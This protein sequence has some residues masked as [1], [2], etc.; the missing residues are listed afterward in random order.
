MGDI[1]KIIAERL[2]T[3]LNDKKIKQVELA[4]ILDIEPSAVSGNLLKGKFYPSGENLYKLA[5]IGC[6]INWLL[7]GE[8]LKKDIPD[9]NVEIKGSSNVTI[10]NIND[11]SA[12]N[13]M[14]KELLKKYLD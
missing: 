6:D 13:K 10:G 12:E 5:K 8:S 4:K 7:T 14:L 1:K 2:K 3:W 11:I 9:T